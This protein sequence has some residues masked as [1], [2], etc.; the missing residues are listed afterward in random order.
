MKRLLCFLM[1]LLLIAGCASAEEGIL[2][3]QDERMMVFDGPFLEE[4]AEPIWTEDGYQSPN[5]CVKVTTTY[6][7][8]KCDIT[9]ADIY[10]RTL[11]CFIRIFGNDTWGRGSNYV[12]VFSERANAVLCMSGD[13]SAVFKQG[14]VVGNGHVWLNKVTTKRD[15]AVL[16]KDGTMECFTKREMQEKGIYERADEVWQTFMFGPRLLDENGQAISQKK[17]F[18]YSDV[19]IANPRGAI[20]YIE[21]G[22]YV[23]VLAAGRKTQSKVNARKKNYGLNLSQLSQV[24]FDL[25]CKSAYNL[26]G[27]RSCVMCLNS[28]NITATVSGNG[29]PLGDAVALIEPGS[30]PAAFP[31]EE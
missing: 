31:G 11:D 8:Y 3:S 10:V 14:L 4:G 29:R 19:Y 27:G 20:G 5:M 12:K 6:S 24:M 7:D 15:I 18:S 1:A 23:L 13:S 26:D 17:D 9:V 22:H 2:Y 28:E 16:W 25:G 30:Y 21:P